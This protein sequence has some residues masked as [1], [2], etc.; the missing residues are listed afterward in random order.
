[1]V[2]DLPSQTFRLGEAQYHW[3]VDKH[4]VIQQRLGTIR[5]LLPRLQ[6]TQGR[7]R[8]KA[9]ADPGAHSVIEGM[10]AS[11]LSSL[12]IFG[13]VQTFKQGHAIFVL[14]DEANGFYILLSG[15]LTVGIEGQVVAELSEG[16]VFGELGLLDGGSRES[17]VTVVSADAEVL[18]ISTRRF[19]N[20]LQTVPSFAWGIWE[21][22]AGRRESV[23]RPPPPAP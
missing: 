22:V 4:P 19:Q 6:L 23:R 18:F 13:T 5:H 3:L 14:D 11:Q 9:E 16:D 12:A 10:S 21:T 15:N 1:V 20:L 17:D 8:L 2:A 7:A